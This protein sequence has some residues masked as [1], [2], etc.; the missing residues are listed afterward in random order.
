MNSGSFFLPPQ[1]STVASDIDMLFNFITYT[2]LILLVAIVATIIYF[3]Y[4]YRRRSPDDKTS[5]VDHNN[6]L[7]VAWAVGPFILVVIVF[8]WGFR[9]FM[10]LRNVP[11]DAY[12]IHVT[13]KSW[14]WEF[15]YSS[16]A[17]EVNVLH[18]PVGRP[19]KLVMSSSD[20]IHSFSVP[21]FRVKQDVLPGRYTTLWFEATETGESHIFCTEYCGLSHSDMIG[22]VI[23]HTQEDF[24]EWLKSSSGKPEDMPLAEWGE[25]LYTKYSCNTCHST[26][27]SAIIG[28]T[29][30]GIWGATHQFTNGTS[31]VVDE[32]Y[33]RESIEVPSAKVVAGYDPVM[34]PFTSFTDEDINAIIEFIKGLK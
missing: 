32:N 15:S 24:D 9:G 5:L 27:G 10:D 22:K 19:I 17:R 34:P 16:G 14:L 4:K 26:D 2:G 29:F 3:A 18:V 30:Q 12:E 6:A 13:G 25:M 11:G 7:E 21:D 23:V 1:K 8:V 28:P 20:V 33:I 31:A